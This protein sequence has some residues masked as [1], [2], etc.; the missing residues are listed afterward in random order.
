[1]WGG[2]FHF[3]PEN[4]R[5]PKVG[6][7]IIW[8]HWWLGNSA[9]M[10]GSSATEN[11]IPPLRTVTA[12]NVKDKKRFSDLKWIMNILEKSLNDQLVLNPTV[13]QVNEMYAIAIARVDLFPVLKM[14]GS[15][16][17][18]YVNFRVQT[19]FAKSPQ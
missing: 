11:T 1:M 9:F 15:T 17:N 12:R 18:K 13:A 6:L 10:L 16:G 8:Q 3:L 19:P 7:H 14:C 2:Q 4:Y 5:L